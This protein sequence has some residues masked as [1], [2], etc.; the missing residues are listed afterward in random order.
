M[1]LT[2]TRLPVGQLDHFP[3]WAMYLAHFL[4]QPATHWFNHPTRQVASFPKIGSFSIFKIK[5]EVGDLDD[6]PPQN[7]KMLLP[8]GDTSLY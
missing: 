5:H 1:F 4:F 8:L 3:V 2:H 7:H 6:G